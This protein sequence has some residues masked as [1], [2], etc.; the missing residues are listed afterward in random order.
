MAETTV[1][2]LETRADCAVLTLRIGLAFIWIWES[3]GTKFLFDPDRSLA[4]LRGTNLFGDLVIPALNL[5]CAFELMIGVMLLIGLWVRP[6]AW[7]QI[8]VMA[9]FMVVIAS[10]YPDLYKEPT[11]PI[12]KNIPIMAAALATWFLG[13]DSRS[14]D[15]RRKRAMDTGETLSSEGESTA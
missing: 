13:P 6:L 1:H 10:V 9:V 5:I 8:V 11:A 3:L 2:N 4:L 14:L 12:A 7:V 15:A